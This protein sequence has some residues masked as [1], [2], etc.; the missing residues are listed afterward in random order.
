MWLLVYG[1]EGKNS[2]FLSVRSYVISLETICDHLVS[3]NRKRTNELNEI[4]FFK[5]S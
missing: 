2:L 1:R 3:T 4:Y 5:K